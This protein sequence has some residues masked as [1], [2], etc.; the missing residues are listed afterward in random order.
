[1]IQKA[2]VATGCVVI[3]PGKKGLTLAVTDGTRVMVDGQ[4]TSADKLQPD[5]R[6]S[7]LYVVRNDIQQALAIVAISPPAK[8]KAA[9]KAGGRK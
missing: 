5:Q 9:G 2:D 3:G 7:A 6:A 4:E 8:K 1:V